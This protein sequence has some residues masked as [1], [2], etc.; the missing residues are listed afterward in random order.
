MYSVT[1]SRFKKFLRMNARNTAKPG[2]KR[3]VHLMLFYY[4]HTFS[5][6]KLR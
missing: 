6:V 4:F 1:K 3:K 5:K 2:T